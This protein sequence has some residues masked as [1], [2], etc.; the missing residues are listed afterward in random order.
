MF[1]PVLLLAALSTILGLAA[2]TALLESIRMSS[3]KAAL[4]LGSIF[5]YS[6][7]SF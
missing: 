2:A 1:L 6:A 4:H 7:I 5:V 3:T